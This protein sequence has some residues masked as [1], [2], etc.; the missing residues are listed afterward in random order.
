MLLVGARGI[1]SGSGESSM[2]KGC[3][4]EEIGGMLEEA[5]EE[6]RLT[7][8]DEEEEDDGRG[9]GRPWTVVVEEEEEEVAERY[10]V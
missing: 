2:Q 8:E 4:Y 1:G 9:E 5:W 3:S 7:D 10:G 6:E